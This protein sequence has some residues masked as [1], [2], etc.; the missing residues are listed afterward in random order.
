VPHGSRVRF[1]CAVVVA[2]SPLLLLLSSQNLS[3]LLT[4]PFSNSLSLYRIA[5]GVLPQ[6]S[7]A[8]ESFTGARAACFPAIVAMQRTVESS[9][10]SSSSNDFQLHHHKQG[11]K[12]VTP[13]A[14]Y[15]TIMCLPEYKIDS[16]SAMGKKPSSMVGQLAFEN[17]TFAYPTR[18]EV[19]V[20][21]SFNLEIKPGTTVALVGPSGQGKVRKSHA[22]IGVLS[23]LCCL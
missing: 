10:R 17:V 3:L 18:S 23:L 20:F 4:F 6:V 19:N 13:A 9:R 14:A 5:A 22:T 1:S 2:V 15:N 21:Q 7:V 12:P 8:I 16:S 11:Q